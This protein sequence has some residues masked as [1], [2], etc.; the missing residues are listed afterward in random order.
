MAANCHSLSLDLHAQWKG[1]EDTGQ[2]RFTPPTQVIAALGAALDQLEA[3]GGVATRGIRYRRHCELLIAGLQ[4]L[5][6]SMYLPAALQSPVIVTVRDPGVEW[7]RFDDLYQALNSQDI[8][9]YPGKLAAEESFRI[10]CIGAITTADIQRTL[11]AIGNF[12]EARR[13]PSRMGHEGAFLASDAL[14]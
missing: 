10:G 6:F 5:G 7:F 14:C 2:W 8:V 12:V 3:E 4:A 1:F 13:P 9:I 11:V